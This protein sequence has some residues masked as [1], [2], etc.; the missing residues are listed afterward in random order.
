MSK[1][2]L[3]TVIDRVCRTLSAEFDAESLT[4]ARELA[5]NAD[6][7]VWTEHL[8]SEIITDNYIDSIE[9]ISEETE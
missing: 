3:V 8:D 4:G 5:E 7:D 9:E 6:G 1:R 2:Y